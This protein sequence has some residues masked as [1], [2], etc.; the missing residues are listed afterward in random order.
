MKLQG[1]SIPLGA[2]ILAVADTYD[3]MVTDRPYR[4]RLPIDAAKAELQKCAGRLFDPMVVEA[5]LRMLSEKEQRLAS[6]K[7]SNKL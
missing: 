1:E 3:A 4:K 2:R 6:T 5:F 7:D